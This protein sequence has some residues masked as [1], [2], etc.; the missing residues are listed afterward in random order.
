MNRF[1]RSGAMFDRICSPTPPEAYPFSGMGAANVGPEFTEKEYE[2]LLELEEI[3]RN[4]F[5][6]GEVACLSEM[7]LVLRN[8]VVNS[9]RWK[10]WLQPGEDSTNF[11]L[12]TPLR[13]D[14]LVRTGCRYI[15][16]N[17]EVIAARAQLYSNLEN[18][19]ILAEEI[20]LSQ[21]ERAMDK[22][23]AAFNLRNLNDLL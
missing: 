4:L 6:E 12:I 8:A 1:L 16:Q 19:G 5:I 10:K 22:Y 13:C 14:W 21:I 2:G 9:G 11:D 23:F 18:Q 7:N 3:E 17:P 15:W 20:V